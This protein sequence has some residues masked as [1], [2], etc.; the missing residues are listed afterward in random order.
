MP[1]YAKCRNIQCNR[2]NKCARYM[3]ISDKYWQTYALFNA[4]NDSKCNHFIS[5][6]NAPFECYKDISIA[7]KIVKGVNDN[8]G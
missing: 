7:D 5:L 4:D 6:K 8:I 1:D 3:M 2:R